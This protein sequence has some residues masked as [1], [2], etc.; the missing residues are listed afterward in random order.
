MQSRSSLWN[1]DRRLVLA[2]KS[3]ARRQLLASTGM[4]FD[5]DVADIDERAVE[6]AFLGGGGAAER[7]PAHLAAAKA[8]EVSRRRSGALCIGADQVLSLEGRIFH[9]PESVE[10]ARSNLG[11]LSGRTHRLTSAVAIARDGRVEFQAEDHAEMTMRELDAEQIE[12]YLRCVGLDA[13]SSV[14]G[15]QVE[16]LGVHLFERMAGAHA[17]ILG[18]PTLELLA[19]LRHEGALWL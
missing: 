4:P 6:R 19:W 1:P 12:L 3:E 10:E 13:L 15:Y 7:L 14:G 11:A 17:T 16:K 5:T 18:L 9:K 2:S 8:L